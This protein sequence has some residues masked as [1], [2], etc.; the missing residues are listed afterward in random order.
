MLKT[1]DL[2]KVKRIARMPL[3]TDIH[4]TEFSPAIV[5]H[6]FAAFAIV[7]LPRQNERRLLCKEL[8][9]LEL[10]L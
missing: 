3:M 2:K 7:F 9:Y 10:R 8:I 1:T 4:E 5:Q 6:S